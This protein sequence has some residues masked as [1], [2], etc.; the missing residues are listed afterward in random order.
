M[1][2]SAGTLSRSRS[3]SASVSAMQFA[4]FRQRLVELLHVGGVVPAMM[5]LQRLLVDVRLECV[6]GIGQVGEREWVGLP[7]RFRRRGEL[8]CW[9]LTSW[10]PSRRVARPRSCRAAPAITQPR[11]ATVR[12]RDSVARGNAALRWRNHGLRAPPTDEPHAGAPTE[13]TR[14]RCMVDDRVLRHGAPRS[15]RAQFDNPRT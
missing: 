13:Q 2:I 4:V 7:R 1:R 14:Q 12:V 15:L 6:V 9:E 3:S 8:R 10:L 11:A 5:E